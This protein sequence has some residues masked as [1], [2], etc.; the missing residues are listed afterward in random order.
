[1]LSRLKGYFGFAL[2]VAAFYF[3]LSHHFIFYSLKDFDVLKKQELTM[4]YTFYSIR[5]HSAA[6]TMHIKE[7][8]EAGIEDVL[9][10]RGIASEQDLQRLLNKIYQEGE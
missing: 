6:E 1:M 8:R 4:K 9:L 10:D 5:Q 2:A 3:L 7:L